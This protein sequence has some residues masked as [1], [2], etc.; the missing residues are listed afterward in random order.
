MHFAG[1]SCDMEE[2]AKIVKN[3]E[4]EFGHKIYIIEDACHALGS[5]YKGTPVGSCRYSDMAVTS[6]HPV[7]HITTGE[8]G[9]VLTNDTDH[10][11]LLKRLR[12]HGITNQPG[13]VR[14]REFAF[15]GNNSKKAPIL[16]PWYYEQ[17]ELGYNYRIT[18]IQCALGIT[19]LNK[20]NF[21]NK[22]RKHI[23]KAYNSAF[24]GIDTLH[25]PLGP[26]R[27]LQVKYRIGPLV[28]GS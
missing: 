26:A 22:K 23:V 8:G 24:Q 21:F 25:I 11:Q 16:N 28:S 20:L 13:E 4:R 12:S 1:Q 3:A 6:F 19:Q 2:I 5:E 7:K 10:S 14:F 15:D 17:H 18:D 9:V 27:N